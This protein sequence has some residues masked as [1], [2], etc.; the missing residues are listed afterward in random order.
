MYP[1]GVLFGLGFDTSSE[2]AVLGIASIQAAKGTD[3]W[4]ILIFPLL[5]TAGMCMLDTTDG[6]LMMA[7]YTRTKDSRDPVIVLYYSIVLTVVTVIA[8]LII[9]VIQVLSL[10]YNVAEPSGP[11]W[12][13]VE[14]AGEN[15]EIIGELLHT[16]AS[17]SN[18]S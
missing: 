17:E 13:G 1:I 9:G 5:F 11:F 14:R 12:D 15:Y 6:A 4:V 2:I 3:I 16:N 8:A 7:L 10:I 18:V